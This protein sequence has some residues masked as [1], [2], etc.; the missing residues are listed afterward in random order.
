MA[1]LQFKAS[2]ALWLI[3]VH[4]PWMYRYL[5]LLF[6]LYLHRSSIRSH[7]S[8]LIHLEFLQYSL[9]VLLYN[10]WL[11]FDRRYFFTVLISSS[12]R[13]WVSNIQNLLVF[14]E[15][16]DYPQMGRRAQGRFL[17][18]SSSSGSS[19]LSL[20]KQNCNDVSYIIWFLTICRLILA[21]EFSSI[22][23]LQQT[24]AT[25]NRITATSTETHR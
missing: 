3:F 6:F 10:F 13:F 21:G 14:L 15:W 17:R 2:Y 9:W 19:C 5:S 22:L 25:G 20:W 4:M 8:L 1:V 23:C 7:I 18:K 16:I 11:N 12:L 24:G